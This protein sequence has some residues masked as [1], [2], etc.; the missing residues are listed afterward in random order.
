MGEHST[1]VLSLS[2]IQCMDRCAA[3]SQRVSKRFSVHVFNSLLRRLAGDVDRI[4]PGGT[5]TWLPP[6]ARGALI[7]AA[8]LSPPC[9]LDG[10]PSARALSDVVESLLQTAASD[11]AQLDLMCQS[12]ILLSLAPHWQIGHVLTPYQKSHQWESSSELPTAV[13]SILSYTA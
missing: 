1:S 4:I 3:G 12:A 13:D 10:P 2:H 6:F 9:R 11:C 7:E 5:C 8:R